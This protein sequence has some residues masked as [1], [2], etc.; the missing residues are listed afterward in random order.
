MTRIELDV[1]RTA[2]RRMLTTLDAVK[3]ECR[4]CGAWAGATCEKYGPPPADV[5][6]VGCDE[7][8]F[9]DIPF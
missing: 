1:Q 5:V 7:W 8:Q 9:D 6:P 2:L 4:T 3:V